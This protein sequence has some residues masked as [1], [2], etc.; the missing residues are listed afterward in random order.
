MHEWWKRGTS[1]G[2]WTAQFWIV[3]WLIQVLLLCLFHVVCEGGWL[4]SFASHST[5]EVLG[6][7]INI[8]YTYRIPS[9][10]MLRSRAD[11]IEC[12]ILRIAQ[13]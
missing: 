3:H 2:Y 11:R 13:W 1:T 8:V 6:D 7:T 9:L 12:P 5:T 4:F 10:W